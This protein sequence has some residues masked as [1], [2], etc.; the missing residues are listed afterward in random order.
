MNFPEHPFWDY[1]LALY[2]QPG[3]ADA[4]LY[5]QDRYGLNVNIVLFCVWSASSG[6]AALAAG[7]LATAIR[8]VSDWQQQVVAPL[9]HIRRALGREPLGIPEFLLD[10]YRPQIEAAELEAEHVEQL[11]LADFADSMSR[12]TAESPAQVARQNLGVYIE[13]AGVSADAD[14]DASLDTLIRIA[15]SQQSA[16]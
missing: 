6:L 1:S 4:C 14:L 8:R 15:F 5:L 2:K 16:S 10:T 3:V 9:R 12:G 7:Q 13:S 11:V